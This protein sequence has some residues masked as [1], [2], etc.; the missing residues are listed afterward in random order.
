LYIFASKIFGHACG[1]CHVQYLLEKNYHFPF[2]FPFGLS[3]FLIAV[4][5][6]CCSLPLCW[7]LF[8]VL[9]QEGTNACKRYYTKDIGVEDMVSAKK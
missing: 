3:D 1:K 7:K 5:L 2:R 8:C 9:K 6:Q 4:L